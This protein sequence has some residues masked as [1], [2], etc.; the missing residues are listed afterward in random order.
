MLILKENLRSE[1]LTE[2]VM[3]ARKN[4][5]NYGMLLGK[6]LGRYWDATGMLLLKSI[7]YD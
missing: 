3:H 2:L 1:H 7:A 6:G 4:I 5:E